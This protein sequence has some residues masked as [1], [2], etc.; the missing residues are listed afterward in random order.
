MNFLKKLF[1]P[2]KVVRERSPRIRLL[3]SDAARLETEVGDFPILNLSESGI[4]FLAEGATLPTR[5]KANILLSG[6]QVALE[7]EIVRRNGGQM[8]A[9]FLGD[10]KEIRAA[11]RRQ[12]TEEIRATEMSEVDSA[13]LARDAAGTPRWFYA[14]GNYELFFLE[15]EGSVVRVE[16]EWNGRVVAGYE[17]EALRS[18]T[19]EPEDRQE[20]G[21]SKSA[22]VKW[23]SEVKESDRAK[24]IRIVEN[25]PGLDPV[26]RGLVV[27]LLRR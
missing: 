12:F 1:Q 22:L 26:T 3:L 27:S 18:G 11:L 14:P 4:G 2:K 5:L 15:A 23:E 9:R 6:E 21:H 10:A 16:I 24:A 20:P 25:V 17:N 8:G 19:I 7:L 13:H